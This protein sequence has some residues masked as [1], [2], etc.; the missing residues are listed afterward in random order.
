M[1]SPSHPTPDLAPS[2]TPPLPSEPDWDRIIAA[3]QTFNV[4]ILG[5]L[6]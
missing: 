1:L 3:C 6:E 4:D 5:D 2:A